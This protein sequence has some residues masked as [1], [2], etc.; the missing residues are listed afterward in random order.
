MEVREDKAEG[1]RNGSDWVVT[2]E[3]SGGV[4]AEDVQMTGDSSKTLYDFSL[5]G[6]LMGQLFVQFA[7]ERLRCPRHLSGLLS[8]GVSCQ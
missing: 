1:L 2:M 5:A 6:A 4:E 7:L 8:V 3:V